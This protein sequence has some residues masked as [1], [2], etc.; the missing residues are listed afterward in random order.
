MSGLFSLP[1]RLNPSQEINR[2]RAK[3]RA[4]MVSLGNHLPQEDRT[5]ESRCHHF[6]QSRRN[7]RFRTAICT[8]EVRTSSANYRTV[9]ESSTAK[10]AG[11]KCHPRWQMSKLASETLTL[12]GPTDLSDPLALPILQAVAGIVMWEI[13]WRRNCHIAYRGGDLA[14]PNE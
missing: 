7:A 14:S 11:V 10:P 6:D 12:D 5:A 3:D 1:K 8:W 9:A 2:E 4:P 13:N